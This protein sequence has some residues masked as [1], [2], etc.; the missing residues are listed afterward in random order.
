MTDT[1]NTTTDIGELTEGFYRAYYWVAALTAMSFV[2]MR[3]AY[4][5]LDYRL[6][7]VAVATTICVCAIGLASR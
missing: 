3:S 4:P 7:W 2:W 5:A 6:V 1:N